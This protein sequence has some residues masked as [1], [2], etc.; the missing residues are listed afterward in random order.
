MNVWGEAGPRR[1]MVIT[2]YI[3]LRIRWCVSSSHHKIK[4]YRGTGSSRA[5][6]F[7]TIWSWWSRASPVRNVRR[8]PFGCSQLLALR[9]VGAQTAADG[10]GTA[11]CVDSYL[12]ESDT[13]T[14]WR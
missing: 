6:E 14:L 11:S 5:H 10:K 1:I 12:R 3:Q 9:A 2:T 13:F 4:K 7:T 8:S